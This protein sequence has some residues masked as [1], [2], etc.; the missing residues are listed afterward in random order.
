MKPVLSLAFIL[1]VATGIAVDAD[2]ASAALSAASSTAD[3]AVASPG[4]AASTTASRAAAS[5]SITRTAL[6]TAASRTAASKK[7]ASKVRSLSI[8]PLNPP[9]NMGADVQFTAKAEFSDGALKDV[10]EK[11]TWRSSN[12]KFAMIRPS[13]LATVLAS[14]GTATITAVYEGR[15]ASTRLIAKTTALPASSEGA[16]GTA[17]VASGPKLLHREAAY[18]SYCHTQPPSG[19]AEPQKKTYPLTEPVPALCYKCHARFLKGKSFHAPV[20]GGSCTSCH[21]PHDKGT[22]YLLTLPVKDLCVSCHSDVVD[23]E[24]VHGPTAVGACTYCHRP[25]SSP[26]E[27]LLTAGGV[28]LC[29]SCHFD[30]QRE[31]K[32]PVVHPALRGGCTSCHDPHGSEARKFLPAEGAALCFSCH[33]SIESKVTPS[34]QVVHRPINTEQGCASCHSPH[35]SDAPMLLPKTGMDLCLDCHKNIIGK[36]DTVLHGPIKSGKC[37]PCHDVHGSPNPKL[38]IK[39]YSSGFYVSYNDS[40]FPLCFRCHSRGLVTTRATTTATRFR[41]GDRNLHYLHVNRKDLGKRCR[42]CHVVHGGPNPKLIATTVPFGTWKLPLNFKKT[43]SGGSCAPGCHQAFSYT[44]N[45]AAAGI[46]EK[47]RKKQP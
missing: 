41:D 44:N 31:L 24:Y 17:R 33:P 8:S 19:T 29:V 30:I 20:E 40:E 42:F 12:K 43:V 15:S 13:G 21:D 5:S 34:G 6:S 28:D 23:H 37:L 22:P 16:T 7:N 36:N 46:A 47:L 14:K 27:H 45:K 39:P 25:H 9:A 4:T 3:Q 10:T 11:A 26:N 35:A 1:V 32:K 2:A 38:L 18:C